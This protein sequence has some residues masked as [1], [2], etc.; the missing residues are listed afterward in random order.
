MDSATRNWLL[1]CRRGGL[2]DEASA[3][4][5]GCKVAD[6]EDFLT[7][8]RKD[9]QTGKESEA[10]SFLAAWEEADAEDEKLEVM[11]LARQRSEVRDDP[12]ALA[13]FVRRQSIKRQVRRARELSAGT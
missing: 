3:R 6:L 7:Q 2:D 1:L 13:R 5:A 9:L 4:V 10:R 12:E 11:A 8:G